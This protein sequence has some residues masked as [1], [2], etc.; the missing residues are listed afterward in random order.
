MIINSMTPTPAITMETAVFAFQLI[1]HFCQAKHSIRHHV[2]TETAS[3]M[4]F[5]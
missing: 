2:L 3:G 1:F 4:E 5:R